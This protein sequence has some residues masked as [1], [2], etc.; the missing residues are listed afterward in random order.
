MSFMNNNWKTSSVIKFGHLKSSKG[1]F[2]YCALRLSGYRTEHPPREWTGSLISCAVLSG[3][4]CTTTLHTTRFRNTSP[5]SELLAPWKYYCRATVMLY[6]LS[7]ILC[8]THCALDD[9]SKLTFRVQN[10]WNGNTGWLFFLV[11]PWYTA[12][13]YNGPIVGP[14]ARD[15]QPPLRQPIVAWLISVLFIRTGNRR[16]VRVP[17]LSSLHC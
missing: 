12:T 4:N 15:T 9:S 14:R 6:P 5:M 8:E 17:R 16:R 2:S 10:F 11:G 13:F 3:R 7:G 1:Q